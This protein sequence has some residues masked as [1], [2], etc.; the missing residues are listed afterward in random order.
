MS[1]GKVCVAAPTSREEWP[2]SSA[3]RPTRAVQKGRTTW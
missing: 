1:S 3:A 2:F